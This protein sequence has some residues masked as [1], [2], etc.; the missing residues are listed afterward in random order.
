MLDPF[1][2]DLW[3][4]NH[5]E[6]ALGKPYGELAYRLQRFRLMRFKDYAYPLNG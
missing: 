6:V 4:T 3:A 5:L 2:L 1:T